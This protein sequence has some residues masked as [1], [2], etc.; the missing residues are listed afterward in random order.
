MDNGETPVSPEEHDIL[1]AR[2]AEIESDP[3]AEESWAEALAW[4]ESRR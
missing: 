4:L 3:D 1:K 2:M